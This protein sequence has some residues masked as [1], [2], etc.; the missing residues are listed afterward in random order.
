MSGSQRSGIEQMLIARSLERSIAQLDL[1]R[2]SG[3]TVWLEVY[4]LTGDTQFAN[5]LIGTEMQEKGLKLATDSNKADFTVKVFLTAFG[6]DTGQT[7]IGLPAFSAPVV[8]LPVPEIALFKSDRNRGHTQL[9]LYAFEES[10]QKLVEKSA[11][12]DGRSKYD[13]YKVLL[14]IGFS[15]DDLDET[16]PSNGAD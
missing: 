1:A 6:V 14:V 3:K 16:S 9:R 15:V 4:S 12:I 8:N 7:L 13:D 2:F 5:K 10:T 11:L